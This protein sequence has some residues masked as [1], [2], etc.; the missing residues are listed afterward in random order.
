LN[1]EGFVFS[2]KSKLNLI[3]SLVLAFEKREIKILPDMQT[4]NELKNYQ[5]E[6]T[7]SGATR[8]GTQNYHDDCLI[9]LALANWK[10]TLGRNIPLFTA[11]IGEERVA[12]F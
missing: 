5:Y 12:T 2:N 6:L 3:Q 1:V 8:Y 10:C 11:T 4:I 7:R 9:A